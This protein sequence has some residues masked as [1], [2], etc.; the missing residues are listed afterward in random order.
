[1]ELKLKRGGHISG[2]RNVMPPAQKPKGMEVQQRWCCT[3]HAIFFFA[4]GFLLFKSRPWSEN[5]SRPSQMGSSQEFGFS[6]D[7]TQNGISGVSQTILEHIGN[8]P[9]ISLGKISK[10]EGLEC[11]LLAKCEF[12]SVGGSVKDRIAL[13]MIEAAERERKLVPGKNTIIEATSGNTGIGLALVAAVKGYRV[14]ITLHDGRSP[15]KVSVLKALGAEVITAP[16]DEPWDSPKSYFSIAKR[17]EREIPGAILLNQFG[18]S[19]NPM[20]HEFGT[21][22]EIIQQ[23]EIS[24]MGPLDVLVAGA[25][26]GGTLTGLARGLKKR[27]KDVR[28]SQ[29]FTV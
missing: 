26:T 28:V 4:R 17:L 16:A 3:R 10:E 29:V 2:L 20:A 14:I 24:G 18:N 13:R 1:M 8:T 11:T 5:I 27:W 22:K 19:N 23:L 21:A 25:G 9:I 7:R 15:S 12:L 6:S